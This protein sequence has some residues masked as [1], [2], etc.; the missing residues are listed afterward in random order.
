MLGCSVATASQ[1]ISARH[2][3]L[4]SKLSMSCVRIGAQPSSA[5]PSISRVNPH[6]PMSSKPAM[7]RPMKSMTSCQSSSAPSFCPG[8]LVELGILAVSPSV[9]LVRLSESLV[10]APLS[11]LEFSP[12]YICSLSMPPTSPIV[13]LVRFSE[14]LVQL[15]LASLEL[16]PSSVCSPVLS[17]PMPPTARMH[18][19]TSG[20]SQTR[21]AAD[22]AELAVSA[23]ALPPLA[24]FSKLPN[25]AFRRVC[26]FA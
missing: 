26:T 10:Q 19:I 1:P 18:L 12:S 22:L 7:Y 16:S 23:T 4:A 11:S 20:T 17:R 25:H 24:A 21:S 9:T 6:T 3:K 2:A 14:S 15:P 8:A 5:W 13:T